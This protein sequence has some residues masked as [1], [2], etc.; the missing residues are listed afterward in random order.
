MVFNK[1]LLKMVMLN[2]KNLI[3]SGIIL[4]VSIVSLIMLFVFREGTSLMIDNEINNKYKNRDLIVTL[5]ES[6][7]SNNYIKEIEKDNRISEVYKSYPSL[8]TLNDTYGFLSLNSVSLDFFESIKIDKEYTK[9]N[10]ILL[11][12]CLVKDE[13]KIIGSK[14]T[15]FYQE[16]Q[17]EFIVAGIYYLKEDEMTNAVYTSPEIYSELIEENNFFKNTSEFHLIVKN[18]KDLES[19]VE[20]IRDDCEQVY[21]YDASGKAEINLYSSLNK[22]TKYFVIGISVF[23]LISFF[24]TIGVMIKQE[25]ESIAILKSLGYSSK[26]VY[27]LILSILFSL[28]LMIYILAYILCLIGIFLIKEFFTYRILNYI[29]LTLHSFLIVLLIISLLLV[30]AIIIN[31][32]KI[33]KISIIKMMVESE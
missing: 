10:Y 12:S 9:G 4:F 7:N 11:P 18:R 25:E 5:K 8:N 1:D 20:S 22:L 16:K 6:V 2:K 29:V 26:K 13:E 24:I 30:F 21:L 3:F 27:L 33:K 31:Y 17:L 32:F 14:V 15:L 28:I 19:V 23:L